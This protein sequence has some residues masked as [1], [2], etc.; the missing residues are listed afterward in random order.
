MRHIEKGSKLGS[1]KAAW[2]TPVSLNEQKMNTGLLS[3]SYLVRA[4]TGIP[5]RSLRM[6]VLSNKDFYEVDLGLALW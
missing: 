2:K 3:V 1:P 4:W 6:P 5:G